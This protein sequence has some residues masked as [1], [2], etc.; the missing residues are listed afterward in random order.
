[1]NDNNYESLLDLKNSNAMFLEQAR[2]SAARN[3]VRLDG[4]SKNASIFGLNKKKNKKNLKNNK[5]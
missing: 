5:K 1:M 3:D 2:N 4:D